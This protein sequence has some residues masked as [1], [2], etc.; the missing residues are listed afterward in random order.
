MA[1]RVTIY[2]QSSD[3]DIK[4]L[5]R[6]MNAMYVEYD[7]VD[8]TKSKQAQSRFAEWGESISGKPVVEVLRE[9]DAGSVFLKNPDEPTLRQCLMGEGI[10]SVTSYWL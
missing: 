4:R 6:E 5:R 3:A 8:P 7:Y 2:G 10:L 9:D 1:S